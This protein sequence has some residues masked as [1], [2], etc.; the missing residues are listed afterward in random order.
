M[1]D[2]DD[3][4][5]D[6]GDDDDDDETKGQQ[7][8]ERRED[9]SLA[10]ETT[11]RILGGFGLLE[12]SREKKQQ[13]EREY[14]SVR[15]GFFLADVESDAQVF[16]RQLAMAVEEGDGFPCL[17]SH[18]PGKPPIPIDVLDFYRGTAF[19]YRE[20]KLFPPYPPFHFMLKELR[21]LLKEFAAGP[22][23]ELFQVDPLRT[24]GFF[25][26]RVSD[27]LTSRFSARGPYNARSPGMRFTVATHFPG[28]RV[29]YSPAYFQKV[30]TV[31]GSPTTPVKAWIQ[32][33]RYTF[34]VVG[35]NGQMRF[36]PG[37][38]SVPPSKYAHL[39]V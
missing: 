20:D 35:V 11:N 13:R 39:I 26:E 28:E 37:Q 3:P 25:R 17:V 7:F 5:R 6:D 2:E 22:T 12:Y 31:F 34:S 8:E 36:D 19:L 38:Y 15:S 10:D 29:H 9:R 21:Y 4:V 14:K 24:V 1:P 18:E 23:F 30:S 27:F 32:P 33:G 16:A